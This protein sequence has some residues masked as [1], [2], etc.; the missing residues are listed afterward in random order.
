MIIIILSIQTSR[1]IFILT[2]LTINYYNNINSINF[3]L[4]IIE[5]LIL[6][7]III[8]F[9]TNKNYKI[10]FKNINFEII[11]KKLILIIIIIFIF[12]I[13]INLNLNNKNKIKK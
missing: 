13:I 8:K 12:I 6:I 2:I 11:N 10:L 7:N 3:K 1:I 9:K 4:I 5:I